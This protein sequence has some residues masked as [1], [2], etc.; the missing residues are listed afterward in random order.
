MQPYPDLSKPIKILGR[1]F[2]RNNIHWTAAVPGIAPLK[3][4]LF[5]PKTLTLGA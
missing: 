5:K 4:K 3:L 2:P 1:R